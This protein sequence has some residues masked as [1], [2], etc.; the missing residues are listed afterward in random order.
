L[1]K[2]RNRTLKATKNARDFFISKSGLDKSAFASAYLFGSG[3]E[4][5]ALEYPL[6][7]PKTAKVRYVDRFSTDELRRQYPELKNYKLVKVDVIDDAETLGTFGQETLDF[8]IASHVLEHLENPV[9]AMVNFNRVLRPNGILFICL[10]DKRDTFDKTRQLTPFSHIAEDYK[11]GPQ[12]SRDEHLR[13]WAVN[14]EALKSEEQILNRINHLKAISG[15]IHFHVW[16]QK[17]MFE[18]F[19]RLVD[20]FKLPLELLL[21]MK[22]GGEE[23]FIFKKQDAATKT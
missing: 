13:D 22:F 10:P 14:V 23:I 9:L 12:S 7:V 6:K 5:G 4:I 20:D 21:F 11:N 3:I 17:E 19:N 18:M 1:H 15:H 2:V 8:V 16:S